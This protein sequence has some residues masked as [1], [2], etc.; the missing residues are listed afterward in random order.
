M[1][2]KTRIIIMEDDEAIIKSL[3]KILTSKGYEVEAVTNGEEGIRR[4]GLR[5]FDLA[6]LDIRLPKMNGTEVL[7]V[8]HRKF[9]EMIKIMI[10]GYPS[11]ENAVASL[12][13][14]ADAYLM[15]PV[16]PYSL[17]KVID[18]KIKERSRRSGHDVRRDGSSSVDGS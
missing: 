6:L 1:S 9:P 10:T 17:L 12:K 5:R 18:E 15:K 13:R 4:C 14:G 7:E 8:L 16:S 11:L 3:K 2:E